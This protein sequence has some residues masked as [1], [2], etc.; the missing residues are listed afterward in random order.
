MTLR[1]K[2]PFRQVELVHHVSGSTGKLLRLKNRKGN[3]VESEI[4]TSSLEKDCSRPSRQ[5]SESSYSVE[6]RIYIF[7]GSTNCTGQ[8]LKFY[9]PV[10]LWIFVLMVL[11]KII[12][13]YFTSS[14]SVL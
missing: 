10:F 1:K 3:K 14:P 11:S 4:R 13:Y 12:D 6:N 9:D 5:V 7:L 2:Q 8:D